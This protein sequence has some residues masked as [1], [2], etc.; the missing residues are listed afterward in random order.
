M[1]RVRLTI[2]AE[3]DMTW[4]VLHDPIPA[5]A[6]HLGRGLGRESQIAVQGEEHKGWAI[7][8]FEERSFEAYRVYYEYL[9]K[10]SHSV[11]YIVRLNQSGRFHVPPSR[12]EAL[13]AP[14]LFG[15]LPNAAI[16]V[17]R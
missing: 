2:D 7:P 1:V 4:V 14:E 11:E 16:E 17:Q 3:R 5:G 10:G 8:A 12:V 13:Y 6:S 15:E 9:P